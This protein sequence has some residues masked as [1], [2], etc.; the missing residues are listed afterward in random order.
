MIGPFALACLDMAGTTVRDD[1]AVDA[2]FAAA[3]DAVGISEGSERYTE[4]LVVVRDTMGWSKADVFARLLEP[5]EAAT[6]TAAFAAELRGHCRRR[7][8]RDPRR[9]WSPAGVAWP[10]GGGLPDDGLR[11][12]DEGRVARRSRVA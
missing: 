1:G 10:R 9:A 6:A 7:R 12:F 11:S 3:L 4:A 8:Q 5:D 2:A